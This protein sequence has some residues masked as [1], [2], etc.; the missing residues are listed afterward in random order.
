[1]SALSDAIEK[2]D[3]SAVLNAGVMFTFLMGIYTTTY[4][5]HRKGSRQRMVVVIITALYSNGVLQLGIQWWYL[6]LAIVNNGTTRGDI[7]AEFF[8]LP[9]WSEV[10]DELTQMLMVILADVLLIW[11]CFYVWNRSIRVIALPV[12]LLVAEV[13]ISIASVMIRFINFDPASSSAARLFGL[14][15]IALFSV[16]FTGSMAATILIAFRIHSMSNQENTHGG[17]FKHVI[18]IVVQSAVIYSL[19]LLLQI[20]YSVQP[21]YAH[22][23]VYFAYCSYASTLAFVLAGLV[24]TIMVARVYA[25]PGDNTHLSSLQHVSRIQFQGQSTSRDV[26]QV[27]MGAVEQM[28]VDAISPPTGEEKHGTDVVSKAPRPLFYLGLKYT[29]LYLAPTS[30]GYS[31]ISVTDIQRLC[32]WASF[33]TLNHMLRAFSYPL[34]YLFSSFSRRFSRRLLA[35]LNQS[36]FDIMCT[37]RLSP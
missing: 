27:S 18:E 21:V 24:P 29:S 20:A 1:M 6:K 2:A 34:R 17:R 28:E 37:L 11:R 13:G 15:Q 26:S 23:T 14:M 9:L 30:P 35:Q 7:L 22:E 3:I 25:S 12:L 19:A 10:T 33:C 8:N 5:V 4:L 31:V 16:S 32:I 36:V